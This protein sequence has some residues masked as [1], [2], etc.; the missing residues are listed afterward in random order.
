MRDGVGGMSGLNLVFDFAGNVV[1]PDATEDVPSWTT[2]FGPRSPLSP[3]PTHYTTG[4]GGT[5]SMRPDL[6]RSGFQIV[7]GRGMLFVAPLA[8]SVI[9]ADAT[10]NDYQSYVVDP[11][12][13]HEQQGAW[14]TY[15]S[16]LTGTF[17]IGSGL[18]L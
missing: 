3:T 6:T 5:Y 11:L 17:G 7:L 14:H 10:V 16:M 8:A 1:A 9:V 18:N 2:T 4:A 15:S 13:A 12:P